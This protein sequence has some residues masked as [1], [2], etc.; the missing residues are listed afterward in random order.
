MFYPDFDLHY[1]VGYGL[2]KYSYESDSFS[3]I[4]TYMVEILLVILTG[5]ENK[6]SI[7]FLFPGGF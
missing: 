7:C 3:L 1:K 2:F 4:K 6:L 5:A